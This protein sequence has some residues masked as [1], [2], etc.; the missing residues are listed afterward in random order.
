MLLKVHALAVRPIV[1]IP[2]PPI[3]D[4]VQPSRL[5]MMVEQV[6]ERHFRFDPEMARIVYDDVKAVLCRL[7]RNAGQE[8][9]IR[10]IPLEAAYSVLTRELPG[11]LFWNLNIDTGN[12]R[13]RQVVPPECKGS[14][15]MY[16]NLHETYPLPSQ[17]LQKAAVDFIISSY[18]VAVVVS[19]RSGIERV[20]P[21]PS[22]EDAPGSPE[23]APDGTEGGVFVGLPGRGRGGRPPAH[24]T[25]GQ[26]RPRAVPGSRAEGVL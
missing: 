14:A 26:P 19:Q 15:S 22:R 11:R 9:A 3:F 13:Q 12:L 24:V 6:P 7:L 23:D 8:P 17:R 25:G 4:E 5:Q 1:P 18:L 20:F 16:S 2:R 21:S 10:L